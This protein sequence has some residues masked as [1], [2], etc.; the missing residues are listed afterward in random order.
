MAILRN[1]KV[2]NFNRLVI[3]HLNI[4]S[5]RNKFEF[6]QKLIQGNIDILVLTETKLDESFPTQQ[7][8][9]DGYTTPFRLDRNKNGGGIFVYVREDIPCRELKFNLSQSHIEGI[10][11]EINLRKTKWL[12]F[13]GY[14]PHKTNIENF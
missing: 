8:K 5:L 7:F 3:G 14:N 12:V 6:L 4:N 9:M 2:K 13:G 10:F 11:L 1:L